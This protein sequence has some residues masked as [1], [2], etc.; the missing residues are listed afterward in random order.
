MIELRILDSALVLI[1][2][3]HCIKI[4]LIPLYTFR[5]MLRT[6]FLLQKLRREVTSY[7]LVTGLW[8][9]HSAISHMALCPCIM[10]HSI[11]FNTFRDML[12]TKVW[13]TDGGMAGRTDKRTDQAA[14]ICSPFGKHKYKGNSF[15]VINYGVMRPYLKTA[16]PVITRY[17]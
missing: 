8:F 16:F 13:R 5:D 4:H 2:V 7:I 17:V 15:I 3:Y 6:S 9:L 11:I 10:F 14:T 12:R 1:A